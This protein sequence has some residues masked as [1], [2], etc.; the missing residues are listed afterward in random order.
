MPVD[1]TNNPTAATTM[2]LLSVVRQSLAGL[3]CA[4]SKG[5]WVTVLFPI[6]SAAGDD[7]FRRR[8]RRR[9]ALNHRGLLRFGRH[10][11]QALRREAL[12]ARR[13]AQRVDLQ[14]E[15]SIDFLLR[16]AFLLHLFDAVTV[17]EEFEMLPRRK[18][19]HRD[20]EHADANRT[21]HLEVPLAIDFA[22][23][24]VVTDV[25][26]DCVFEFAAH[27]A[28]P[29]STAR[30]FALR[31]LGLRS[32]SASLGMSGRFVRMRS[33]ASSAASARSVCFTIRSSS[34]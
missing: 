8:R 29:I 15:M 1:Q 26:L 24:R 12:D 31:A 3:P 19:K 7:R 9:H 16:G 14:T 23:D 2:R 11:P 13:G 25:F 32:I 27:R 30:S 5:V 22:D 20:E 17:T 33:A 10:H 4:A 28:C 34:E 6:D 21:P 18:Q